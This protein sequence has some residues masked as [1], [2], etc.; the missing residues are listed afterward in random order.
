MKN[1]R[2]IGKKQFIYSLRKL[3]LNNFM[4]W[5]ENVFVYDRYLLLA[6]R[7]YFTS[8]LKRKLY[9]KDGM[10]KSV[11]LT[12]NAIENRIPPDTYPATAGPV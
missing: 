9:I 4:R 3:L 10:Q 8:Y 5:E 11:V 6:E 7:C 12:K 2:S 1:T